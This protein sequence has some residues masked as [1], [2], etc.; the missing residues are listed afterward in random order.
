MKMNGLR[1]SIVKLSSYTT[2]SRELLEEYTRQP[3]AEETARWRVERETRHLR[4]DTRHAELLAAGGITTAI[5]T[6]HSPEGHRECAGCDGATEVPP[7]WPCRTWDLLDE[8]TG[9]A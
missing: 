8:H 2:V 5:A 9:G 7:D 4:E 3:S 1:D 6:L